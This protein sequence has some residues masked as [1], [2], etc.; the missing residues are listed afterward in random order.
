[1]HLKGLCLQGGALKRLQHFAS[2]SPGSQPKVI[3]VVAS[4]YDSRTASLFGSQCFSK[5]V[6]LGSELIEDTL[7]FDFD[8]FWCSH[9][10]HP[11]QSMLLQFTMAAHDSAG[12]LVN[13]YCV[14]WGEIHFQQVRGLSCVALMQ[15]AVE[16]GEHARV[17]PG[18]R[19]RHR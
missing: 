17:R 14:A 12:A 8:V 5:P 3:R 10:M 4:L 11:A 15:T 1:M 18:C 19:R 16:H 2:L 9:G 7:R 13:E 6:A